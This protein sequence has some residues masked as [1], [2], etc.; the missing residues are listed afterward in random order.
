MRIWVQPENINLKTHFDRINPITLEPLSDT[1]IITKAPGAENAAIDF[2]SRFGNIKD[3]VVPGKIELPFPKNKEYTVVQGYNSLPT[4]NT[5]WS[6]YAIDFGLGIGDTICAA[7]QGYV[8]GVIEDYKF[9]GQQKKWRNFA[10][11]L[12]VYN[13]ETGL[14][15]QY[16]HLDYRGSLVQL[17]DHILAGQP[18]G[19]AGMTGLTNVEHL[20]FNCLKPV[21]SED[22]LI[23]IPVDSLGQYKTDNLKRGQ[24]ILN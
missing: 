9:G 20:H 19:I 5:D 12:T 16:V 23:S 17:G 22:G 11:V 8:V 21:H 2:A 13:P 7:T 14:F 3:E 1:T 24:I 15:T 4:H 18:I 10:N 6:R